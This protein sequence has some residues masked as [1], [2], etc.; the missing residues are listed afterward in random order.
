MKYVCS[1]CGKSTEK[2]IHCEQKTNHV[3]GLKIISND[4]VNIISNFLTAI[5]AAV[6]VLLF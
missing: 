3:G 4:A 1:V 5:L 2:K 6:Y